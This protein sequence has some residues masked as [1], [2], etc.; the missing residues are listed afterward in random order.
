MPASDIDT[1]EQFRSAAEGALRTGDFDALVALLAPDVE[2]VTPVHSVHG[3]NALVAELGR[4]RPTERIEIE[5]EN[6]EWKSLS[7]GRFSCEIRALYRSKL[8]DEPPYSRDRSFELTVS[9]G[10]VSRFEMRFDA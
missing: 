5:F 2:C 3:A 7:K 8:T 9:D 10:K 1:A 6:G 4:A